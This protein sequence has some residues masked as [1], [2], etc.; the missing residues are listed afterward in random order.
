M[1]SVLAR[2]KGFMPDD[3]GEALYR[4]A[5][6]A[7]AQHRSLPIIEIGSYCGKSTVWLGAAASELGGTVVT[8]DHHRGSE[9]TQPGWEHHDPEVVDRRVNLMDTLPFLRTTL[10]D[11]G[12]EEVVIPIIG[13]SPVVAQLWRTPASLVFIDGGHGDEH[14]AADFEGWAHHVVSGGLL[15]IHDVFENPEDGGRPPYERIYLPAVESGE[16][17]LHD[18]V[19]SLRVL[20]RR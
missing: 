5:C 20:R 18:A 10:Y 7:L 19:G 4:S 12:L 11:A 1:R 8:I 15:A 3:E 13:R 14:A 16:F 6:T 2:T 17:E 9:E